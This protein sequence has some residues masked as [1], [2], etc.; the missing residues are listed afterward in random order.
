MLFQHYAT[1]GPRVVWE[2]DDRPGELAAVVA[3]VSGLHCSLFASF[4]NGSS[5]DGTGWC[6]DH[7]HSRRAWPR[8]QRNQLRFAWHPSLCT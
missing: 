8:T 2:Q 5:G 6:N 3:E 1:C 4:W 7:R